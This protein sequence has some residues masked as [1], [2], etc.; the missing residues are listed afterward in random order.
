MEARLE[1]SMGSMLR[2][3]WLTC[4][5]MTYDLKTKVSNILLLKLNIIFNLVKHLVSL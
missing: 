1:K 4:R 2:C 5:I 3:L